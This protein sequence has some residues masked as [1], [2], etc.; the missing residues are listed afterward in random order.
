M[1]NL[2]IIFAKKN[3][4]VYQGCF[5][6]LFPDSTDWK[7]EIRFVTRGDYLKDILDEYS[8]AKFG[9]RPILLV[10]GSCLDDGSINQIFETVQKQNMTTVVT[11]TTSQQT[12]F[13]SLVIFEKELSAKTIFQVLM[14]KD[15]EK[16]V[17]EKNFK[18]VLEIIKQI[19]SAAKM[20]QCSP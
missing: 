6:A 15:M 17:R 1:S 9:Q 4:H 10:I 7:Y 20:E 19:I 8:P 2:L 18:G 3:A 14:H 12:N 5:E 16:F 13:D 11:M